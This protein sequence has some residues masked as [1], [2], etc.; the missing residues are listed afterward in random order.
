MWEG[1]SSEN[2]NLEVGLGLQLGRWLMGSYT[3]YLKNLYVCVC[4]HTDTHEIHMYMSKAF[5]LSGFY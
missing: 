5:V 3:F 1:L 4:T 2:R